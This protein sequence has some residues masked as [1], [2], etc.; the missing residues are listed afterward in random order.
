MMAIEGL[1]SICPIFLTDLALYSAIPMQLSAVAG[2]VSA[3]RCALTTT[4]VSG[5]R[6]S[7]TSMMMGMLEAGRGVP[8]LADHVRKPDADNPRGY[9]K[10]EKVKGMKGDDSWLDQCERKAVKI[11]SQLLY[12]LPTQLFCS[13]FCGGKIL[14]VFSERYL[15]LEFNAFDDFHVVLHLL[16]R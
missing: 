6:R 7:G 2:T 5:L 1:L 8:I 13:G 12:F 16:L 11:V 10:Y 9:S 3:E 15:L 14:L 4:G